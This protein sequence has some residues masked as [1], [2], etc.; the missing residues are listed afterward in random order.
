M[1]TK[2]VSCHPATIMNDLDS[3]VVFPPK[4]AMVV[5]ELMMNCF[6]SD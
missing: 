2:Y 6:G 3:I 4:E 1:N 5:L